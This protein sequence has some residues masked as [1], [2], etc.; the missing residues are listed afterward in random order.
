MPKMKSRVGRGF[1]NYTSKQLETALSDIRRGMNVRMSS[2][3]HGIPFSSLLS[4][5][6]SLSCEMKKMGPAPILPESYETVLAD[7]ILAMQQQRFPV[8]NLELM[9]SICRIIKSEKIVT[10]FKKDQPG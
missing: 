10:T 8:T 4:Y 7:W 9:S 6:K 3:I 1:R 2:T 5:S